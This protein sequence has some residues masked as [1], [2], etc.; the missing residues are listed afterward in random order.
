MARRVPRA[1]LL[2]A[3]PGDPWLL[4]SLLGAQREEIGSQ[5]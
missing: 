3:W 4:A 5:W 2:E 1:V